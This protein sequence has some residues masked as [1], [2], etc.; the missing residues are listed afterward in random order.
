[1]PD[2][3]NVKGIVLLIGINGISRESNLTDT[4]TLIDKLSKNIQD[5]TIY[6]Q[7]VFPVGKG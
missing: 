7:R 2:S 5:K 1:M 6:V 4:K 3:N